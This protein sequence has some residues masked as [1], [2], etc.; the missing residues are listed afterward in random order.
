MP[1]AG[2][3]TDRREVAERHVTGAWTLARAKVTAM[4]GEACGWSASP[5]ARRCRSCRSSTAPRCSGTDAS[6]SASMPGWAGP[7]EVRALGVEGL[8]EVRAPASRFPPAS[9]SGRCGLFLVLAGRLLAGAALE[10][11]GGG[12][13]QTQVSADDTGMR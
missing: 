9:R 13:A 8:R 6:A 4:P 2:L 5:D 7:V 3:E 12:R 10:L 1:L 11:L